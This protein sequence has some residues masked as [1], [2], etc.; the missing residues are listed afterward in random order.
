MYKTE[1]E[2]SM[3]VC[4]ERHNCTPITIKLYDNAFIDE[5]GLWKSKN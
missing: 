3:C 5:D 1:T 2:N 4:L